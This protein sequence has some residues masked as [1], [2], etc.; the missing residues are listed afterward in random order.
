[1]SRTKWFAVATAATAIASGE[2]HPNHRAARTGVLCA[3]AIPIS[4]FQPTC[5]LG[6]AA[7]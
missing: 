4:K 1:M 3:S 6:M 2:S 7:Y 5:K